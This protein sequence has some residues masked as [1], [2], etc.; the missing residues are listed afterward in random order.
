[1]LFRSK[2][3]DW[4]L[5]LGSLGLLIELIRDFLANMGSWGFGTPL[6]CSAAPNYI[7]IRPVAP[8]DL[9][10]ETSYGKIQFFLA[11]FRFWGFQKNFQIAIF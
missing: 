1:M 5:A 4:D 3:S 10:Y 8:S 9:P 7:E 2:N 11:R 6:I